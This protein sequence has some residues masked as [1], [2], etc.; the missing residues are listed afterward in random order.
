MKED[1]KPS[2]ETFDQWHRDPDNW[3]WG[4]FY[5][6]KKDPR[7]FPPKRLPFLGWTVNFANPYSVAV[8]V[9]IVVV[10]VLGITLLPFSK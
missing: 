3:I 5:Y 9:L 2:K 7:I 10:L 8:L 6:N 4:V 1:I